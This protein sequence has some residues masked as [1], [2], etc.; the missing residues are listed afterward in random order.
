M[1]RGSLF[2]RILQR[3]EGDWDGEG[4]AALAPDATERMREIAQEECDRAE[5][6]GET[7]YPAMWRADRLEVVE[8]CLR[9]LEVERQD[10]LTRALPRV[11]CEARFGR[12]HPGEADDA[13]SRDEPIEIE[14]GDR[15]LRVS[16]RIDWTGT[17]SRRP[18]SA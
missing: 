13:L 5:E 1:R 4:P 6:R 11:K 10:P 14:L 3:F 18:D 16:G 8:D 2:H 12:R 9:W 7:G 15:T 17:R